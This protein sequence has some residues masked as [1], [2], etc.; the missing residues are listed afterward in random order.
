MEERKGLVAGKKDF[1]ERFSAAFRCHS[2]F[3]ERIFV[4]AFSQS[5]AC[6]TTTRQKASVVAKTHSHYMSFTLIR[7]YTP[8]DVMEMFHCIYEGHRMQ[9]SG[10]FGVDLCSFLLSRILD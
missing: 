6:M 3:V 2:L 7:M 8:E 4:K 10:T 5:I 1:Q 9:K